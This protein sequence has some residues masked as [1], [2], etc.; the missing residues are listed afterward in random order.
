M[1]DKWQHLY[2]ETKHEIKSN[3]KVLRRDSP[4]LKKK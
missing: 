1:S 4:N 2:R 3:L